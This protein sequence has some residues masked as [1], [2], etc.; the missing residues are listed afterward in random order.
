MF[1]LGAKPYFSFFFLLTGKVWVSHPAQEHNTHICSEKYWPHGNYKMRQWDEAS[2]CVDRF[3]D[4]SVPVELWHLNWPRGTGLSK[5]RRIRI[6]QTAQRHLTSQLPIT[7]RP[8]KGLNEATGNSHDQLA[9]DLTNSWTYMCSKH[10]AP[11][12]DYTSTGGYVLSSHAMCDGWT[13]SVI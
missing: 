2:I 1:S 13:S 11:G 10:R 5:H 3:H 9:C 6:I 7:H 12:S 4:P 8:I